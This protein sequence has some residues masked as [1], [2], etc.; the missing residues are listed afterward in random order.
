ML[1][2]NQQPIASSAD[3]MEFCHCLGLCIRHNDLAFIW[4][5][6]SNFTATLPHNSFQQALLPITSGYWNSSLKVLY[7]AN[8]V[9]KSFANLLKVWLDQL[10]TVKFKCCTETQKNAASHLYDQ[11]HVLWGDQNVFD[12]WTNWM[13]GLKRRS[14][15]IINLLPHHDV[16]WSEVKHILSV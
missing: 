7:D 14:N 1:W 6:S 4:L 8:F 11:V 16:F 3:V 9:L 2:N 10:T 13:N 5:Q 15:I 12:V